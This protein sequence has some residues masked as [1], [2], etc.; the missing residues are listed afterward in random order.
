MNDRL[1]L[2]A[3]TPV[4]N[5]SVT[6]Q[7]ELD[8]PSWFRLAGIAERGGVTVADIMASAAAEFESRHTVEPRR[9]TAI[10]EK[11]MIALYGLGWSD[12]DVG[13]ALGFARSSISHRRALLGVV[14]RSGG[15]SVLVTEQETK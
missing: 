10:Q 14:S 2:N 11:A 1:V 12:A 8:R 7:V 5:R 15:P 9:M 4:E 13:R 6:V 3:P